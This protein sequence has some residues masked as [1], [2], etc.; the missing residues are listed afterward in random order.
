MKYHD[1]IHKYS[2]RLAHHAV[3]LSYLSIHD[4]IGHCMVS[5]TGIINHRG[6]NRE[7]IDFVHTRYSEHPDTKQSAGETRAI[8]YF[9]ARVIPIWAQDECTV[10]TTANTST[11]MVS[12]LCVRN[13]LSYAPGERTAVTWCQG[14]NIQYLNPYNLWQQPI[15]QQLNPY[16]FEYPGSNRCWVASNYS[17]ISVTCFNNVP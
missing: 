7:V 9:F 13:D 6:T 3:I 11:T 5:Q 17:C 10:M 14:L 16:H 4:C 2:K 8:A 15:H 12:N 1:R